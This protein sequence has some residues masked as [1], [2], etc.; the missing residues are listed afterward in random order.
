MIK[1]KNED[2]GRISKDC[3]IAGQ[4]VGAAQTPDTILCR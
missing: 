1:A 2:V 3:V 4:K